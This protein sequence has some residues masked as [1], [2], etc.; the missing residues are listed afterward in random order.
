MVLFN[1]VINL[2][3]PKKVLHPLAKN[4]FGSSL[5]IDIDD[6]IRRPT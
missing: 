2:G 6:F 3:L 4:W 5:Q 1:V